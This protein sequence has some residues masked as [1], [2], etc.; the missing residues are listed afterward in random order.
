[1]SRETV[2]KGLA[3]LAILGG[4]AW[5]IYSIVK[6]TAKCVCEFEHSV[7][8]PSEDLFPF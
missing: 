5:A 2:I 7:T 4:L 1:M 3:I 8:K 6:P